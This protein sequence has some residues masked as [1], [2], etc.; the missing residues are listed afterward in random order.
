MHLY[1]TFIIYLFIYLL[2]EW[3]EREKISDDY[4]LIKHNTVIPNKYNEQIKYINRKKQIKHMK[5]DLNN[6]RRRQMALSWCAPVSLYYGRVCVLL[7]LL[8]LFCCFVF[9]FF[10][11]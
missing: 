1:Y 5:S 10:F 4:I 11:T 9:L 8:L 7:L 6:I 3:R 2:K